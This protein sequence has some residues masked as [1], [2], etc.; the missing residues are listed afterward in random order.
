MAEGTQMAHFSDSL[1]Q[2]EEATKQ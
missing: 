2:C 1:K